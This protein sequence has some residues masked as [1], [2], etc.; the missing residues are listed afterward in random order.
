MIDYVQSIMR[1]SKLAVLSVVASA[2]WLLAS[3]APALAQDGPSLP[4]FPSAQDI[5]DA[6]LKGLGEVIR[7]AMDQWWD[8]SGPVVFG[9]FI[10]LIFGAITSWLWDHLGPLLTSVNFFTRIPPQWTYE[11]PQVVALRARL[12]TL[13][14]AIMG[15]SLVLGI[16]Y[17]VYGL[18]TGK[19]ITRLLSAVPTFVLGTGALLVLP[20]GME[21]WVR[22][23]NATS[24]AL[25]APTLGLP[26]LSQ[27]EALDRMS[28][29]GV[30]G[31]VFLFFGLWFVVLR[32]VLLCLVSILMTVAP[33]AVAVG[34]LPFPLGQRFFSWWLSTFLGVTFVQVLQTACLSIGAGMLSAPVVVGGPPSDA[35]RD[36]MTAAIGAGMIVAATKTPG[37]LL[38]S[39]ARIGFGGAVINTALQ[40]AALATT[41]R[42]LQVVAPGGL[43]ARVRPPT[44]LPPGPPPQTTVSPAPSSGVYVRSI[45]AGAPTA[46]ALPAPKP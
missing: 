42:A 1:V 27:M 41:W 25:A 36:I 7:T 16:L 40:V 34:T 28:A 4:S 31:L 5:A 18:S 33:I 43:Y 38:G 44:G 32:L 6:F 37:L 22:L 3:A 13:G 9:R 26:G 12:N 15:L 46:P 23:C 24:D 45:L 30:V 10:T 39:L 14:V 21:W 8:T 11:L 19:P 2:L 17:G 35:A 20:Q 29:I